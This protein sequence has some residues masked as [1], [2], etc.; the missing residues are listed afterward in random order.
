MDGRTTSVP[1]SFH[2]YLAA[3]RAHDINIARGKAAP[4]MYALL[5]THDQTKAIHG[6]AGPTLPP[7]RLLGS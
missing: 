4:L 3:L 7:I 1:R 6:A 5:R 2:K